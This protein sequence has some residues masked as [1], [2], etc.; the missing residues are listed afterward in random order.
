MKTTYISLGSNLGNRLENLRNAIKLLK[1]IVN[2]LQESIVLETEALLHENMPKSWNLPYLNVVIKCVTELSPNDLLIQLKSIEKQLGREEQYAKWSPRLIDLDILLYENLNIQS[3]NLTIPH[4]ELHNRHFLQHLLALMGNQEFSF[5]S[6]S[7]IRSFVLNPV[8]VGIVN[9]T[10]D[11]FSDGGKFYST[12]KALQRIEQLYNDGASV[13]DLGAQSTRPNALMLSADEEI[14]VL[15]PIL[16]ELRNTYITLSVDTFRDEVV[17]WI[18][19]NDYNVRWINDVKCE[20]K[21]ETL[22][23]I[24]DSNRTICVM[25]SL[26]VPP[27]LAITLPLNENPIHTIKSWAEQKI[28]MLKN[29]G[30]EISKIII[31]PGIGFGKTMDQ[32]I[33][34]LKQLSILKTLDVQ[35]LIGH[36]RKS[37]IQAFTKS[38]PVERDIETLAVS[39]M[40]QKDIDFIRVHDVLNH[41]KFF[42]TKNTMQ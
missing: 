11:S 25:H 31:D 8:L 15:K 5:N 9:V 33:M 39:N 7:F 21:N 27:S 26:T 4:C 28:Y 1:T 24:R 23:L 18:I 14:A 38:T 34:I 42:V 20:L 37:Y 3:T 6:N 12:D 29:L 36:S 13:I 2:I 17:Q 35:V 19:Q 32:N 41:M 16:N 40:I 22:K 10:K 30:F